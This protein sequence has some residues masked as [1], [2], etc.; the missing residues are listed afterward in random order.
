[1]PLLYR[2]SIIVYN[3]SHVPAIMEYSRTDEKELASTAHE[4]LKEISSRT[5]EVLKAHV[6]EI[7]R[8]L[9]EQAPTHKKPNDAGAVDDL[10]ACAAFAQRFANEIPQDRKFVQ[11]M[12]SFALHGTP[13][14]AAKYAV[15]IMMATS[16]KKELLARDLVT[17][18]VKDFKYGSEGFLSR[19]ATLSQL[20]FLVPQ[21]VDEEIDDIIDIAIKQILL[22]VRTPSSTADYTWSEAIDDECAAK[23]WALKILVN[24]LR[25]HQEDST[26]SDIAAPVYTL[27]STLIKKEGELSNT[28]HTPA[29]HKSRL[30]LLAARL[31]LKLCTSK[32]HDAL[33]TPA[34]FNAL[35]EVAQDP[36][37][38][39]RSSFLQRLKKYAAQ[40]KLPQRFYTIPFLLAFEPVQSLKSETATWIRSRAAFFSTIGTHQKGAAKASTVMESVF[41][42]L[43]SLLAHH[44][45]FADT[46][47]D[48]LDFARYIIF[49]LVNVANPDNVSLIYH[50]AQRVKQCSDVISAPRLTN[51]S[52]A[53]VSPIDPNLYHLSDLAQLVINKFAD[54][55]SWSIQTL[56]AKIRLPSSLFVEIKDHE[57][58]VRIAEK[59]YLPEPEDGSSMEDKIEALVRASLRAGRTSHKKR[60]SDAGDDGEQRPSKKAKSESHSKG[61][62]A[63]LPIRKASKAPATKTPKAKKVVREPSSEVPPSSERRRS[64]RVQTSAVSG[65]YAERDDSEDD[66]EMELL[67]EEE[68][69]DEAE[70]E[71]EEAEEEQEEEEE[72]E[73]EEEDKAEEEEAH[74]EAEVEATPA[75]SVNGDDEDGNK[76][77][78]EPTPDEKTQ[79]DDAD[80]DADELSLPPSPSPQPK[81]TPKPNPVSKTTS[82]PH[83]PP[84]PTRTSRRHLPATSSP[85][86]SPPH[87]TDSSPPSNTNTNPK[88]P[89]LV[90]PNT[91]CAV[92]L[93]T[94]TLCTRNLKC[95]THSLTAKRA[96]EGRKR[97]FDELVGGG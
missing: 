19:L 42:R 5:P 41:A 22:Q 32:P 56:P 21:E 7:C 17:K 77:G 24:R 60:K 47:D 28:K 12:T 93:P 20:V 91:H 87:P 92:P 88:K 29:S 70:E 55:H 1:M 89:K 44:P 81:P 10:K 30:R 95:K 69:K 16:D 33:L 85:I 40:S 31:F 74:V 25:S 48:L 23:C 35:A 78:D 82:K 54:A 15:S 43:L 34:A 26:L 9:Q 94:G 75:P 76:H 97:P 58:A 37:L 6:Q 27:L 73:E 80:S 68:D 13:P 62:G 8:I 49:Y 50:V 72:E 11:A 45:D 52:H 3:K 2:T 64:G 59:N 84:A 79:D 63:A 18:S 71:E 14:E 65:K 39:V 57:F 96:V 67:N 4:I 51:G 83:H 86:S 66:E 53:E 38:E 90:D 36:L 46:A 61:K